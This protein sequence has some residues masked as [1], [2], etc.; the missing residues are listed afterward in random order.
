MIS[1]LTF[2]KYVTFS[3]YLPRHHVAYWIFINLATNIIVSSRVIRFFSRAKSAHGLRPLTSPFGVFRNRNDCNSS[4][5]T[6]ATTSTELRPYYWFPLRIYAKQLDYPHIPEMPLTVLS[7]NHSNMQHFHTVG[8]RSRLFQPATRE[9]STW[10]FTWI[11]IG[12]W[13]L[14]W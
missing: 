8:R 7:N 4:S 14:F 13:V 5:R 6:M 2:V 11:Y 1:I 12:T 10:W 3:I 9:G